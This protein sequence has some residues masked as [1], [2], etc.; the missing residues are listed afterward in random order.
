ML[1]YGADIHQT[2]SYNDRTTLQVV[3]EMGNT[4]MMGILLNKRLKSIRRTTKD[5][6]HYI[7]HL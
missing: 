5:G 4:L 2:S 3:V 6:Q 7:M 1:I